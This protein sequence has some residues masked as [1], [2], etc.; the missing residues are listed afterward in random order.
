M[1]NTPESDDHDQEHAILGY[2]LDFCRKL[3]RERDEARNAFIM[4]VDEMVK[5]QSQ[6]REVKREFDEA[7]DTVAT[8]EIRPA[9]AMFHAQRVVD[10]AN[11]LRE[12]RDLLAAVLQKIRGGYGGQLAAPN[13]CENCDFLLPI[14]EALQSITNFPQTPAK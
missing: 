5:A 14:D 8:M 4:A 12:Q 3:E 2:I 11:Q 10:D 13:C 9:A 6:L 1:S 7:R